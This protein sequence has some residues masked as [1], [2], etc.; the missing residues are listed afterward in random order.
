M[1]GQVLCQLFLLSIAEF[2]VFQGFFQSVQCFI[3]GFCAGQAG[4]LEKLC[5]RIFAYADHL[6]LPVV[7][8]DGGLGIGGVHSRGGFYGGVIG[9]RVNDGGDLLRGTVGNRTHR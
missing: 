8:A 4:R 2:G 7:F 5:A 1:R 3:P 9:Q 6:G